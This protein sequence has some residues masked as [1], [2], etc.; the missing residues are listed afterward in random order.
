[1]TLT[2]SL[3]IGALKAFDWPKWI[4]LI[5]TDKI[6]KHF[7]LI[8]WCLPKVIPQPDDGSFCQTNSWSWVVYLEVSYD[9]RTWIWVEEIWEAF[10]TSKLFSTRLGTSKENVKILCHKPNLVSHQFG[11]IQTVPK[12]FFNRKSELCICTIDYSKDEYLQRLSQ[13]AHDHDVLTTFAANAK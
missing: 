10:L 5:R 2:K 8:S 13:H 4:Q 3:R 9:R 12:P 7:R 6:E 11:I 1:M